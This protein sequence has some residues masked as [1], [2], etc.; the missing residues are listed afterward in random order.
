MPPAWPRAGLKTVWK[1][2]VGGGYAGLAVAE[3]RLYSQDKVMEPAEQERVL[4][5]S[6]ENGEVL[7]QQAY[8]VRYGKLDYGVGPRATPTVFDG[9]VYTLGAV[10]H[11]HCLDAR[12][13]EVLWKHDLVRDLGAQLSEWGLAASPVIWRDLVIFHPGLKQGGCFVAFDRRS[14]REAWRCG[15]DPAGY[16]T[17]ILTGE[18]GKEQ[19]IAWTPE[20]VM[21]MD[22]GSGRLHWSVPYKVTYGVSIATPVVHRGVAFVSGYWE[23]SKAIRLG[24]DPADASLLWEDSDLQG[25]MCQPLARDGYLYTL[26]KD[27]GLLCCEIETGRVLWSDDHQ[28]TPRGRNPH[29]VLQWLGKSE[30]AIILNAE[31][32]LILARL[33][34]DGYD[35]QSRTNIVQPSPAPIWA[36]PA[37]AGDSVYARNDREIV[38]VRLLADE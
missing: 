4:C 6:A 2:P 19:L 34:P 12:S 15:D 31:G 13:G 7:W 9:R 37:F 29:A 23:G 32:D 21:G 22:P 14:G 20:H 1:A 36:H 38:R 10:G 3:G 16:C 26:D 8:D 30:R 24:E 28:M 25:I 27:R 17:P 5:L 18:S 35:E 11:V 33:T